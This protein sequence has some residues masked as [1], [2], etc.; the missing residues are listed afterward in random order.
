MRSYIFGFIGLVFAAQASALSLNDISQNQAGES[1]K[2]VLEQS[3]RLAVEQLSQ[4]GGFNKNPDVHIELPG[5]LGKAARTMKMLGKGKQ[6]TALEDSM[7]R[8]AE[9]AIPQAQELLLH[10]IKNM[11]ISDA[12]GILTG[13]ENS[14]T[15]YLDRS[16]RE[17]LRSRFL[18]VIEQ[19]TRSSGL[20]QQYNNFAGQ[21]AN[22]G[23]IEAKDASIENYVAEQALDGLFTIIGEKEAA[24]RQDPAQAASDIAKK[25]FDL[26]R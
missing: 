22:F 14:A 26:L 1:L 25:V 19:V 6:V 3:T 24:I 2:T 23:V 4:P 12:K 11:T 10:A 8:A 15:A 9:Q 21:A 16:S 13:P 5:N 17:Q 20:A 7:N 18:P